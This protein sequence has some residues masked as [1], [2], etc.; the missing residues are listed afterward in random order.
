MGALPQ[1]GGFCVARRVSV[2]LGTFMTSTAIIKVLLS[3]K[4]SKEVHCRVPC[5]ITN[6]VLTP[7]SSG[8][9]KKPFPLKEKK[10]GEGDAGQGTEDTP[11]QHSP[12]GKPVGRAAASS[13]VTKRCAGPSQRLLCT[14]CAR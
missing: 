13:I 9:N 7:A 5:D 3:L 6:S 14:V 11:F 10:P 8:P 12:L 1:A 4:E 2:S